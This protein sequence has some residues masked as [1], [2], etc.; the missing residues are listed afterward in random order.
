MVLELFMLLCGCGL[1][2]SGSLTFWPVQGWIDFYIP[3][4]LF[5][6]G[7]LFGL[8]ITW[9]FI[10]CVGLTIDEKKEYHN[11]NKWIRWLMYIGV[12]YICM[13]AMIYTRVINRRKMPKKERFLLVCNH[14]SVFDPLII[15]QKFSFRDIAFIMKKENMHMPLANRLMWR[16]CCLPIDRD[17]YLQSLE[18]MRKATYLAESNITSIGVFPEGTRSKN[19]QLGEFHEG[20]FNIA[21]KGKLSIVITT[22][23]NTDQIHHRFPFRFTNVRYEVVGVIP[24]EEF[25]DLPAKKVSDMVYQIMQENLAK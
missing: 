2:I 4:I 22:I 13:H 9:A 6:A 23:R 12:D 7:Y 8:S 3:L 1:A 20:C 5:I 25:Q 24:Y 21:I 19:G 18:V 17:N 11:I 16:S 14:L 15:I 10:W